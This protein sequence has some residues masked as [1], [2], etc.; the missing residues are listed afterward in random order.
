MPFPSL[1]RYRASTLGFYQRENGNPSYQER[2]QTLE[3]ALN[4]FMADLAKRHEEHSKL[5]KEI[6]ASTDTQI[7]NQGAS[8]KALEIQI[9]KM[10]KYFKKGDKEASLV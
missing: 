3:E 6:H 1:G 10:G 5:I 7:R 4:K 2:R 9:G 8:I